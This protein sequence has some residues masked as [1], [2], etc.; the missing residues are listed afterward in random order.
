MGD[1]ECLHVLAFASW[2]RRSLL[3]DILRGYFRATVAQK[4]GVPYARGLHEGSKQ[5]LQLYQFHDDLE[6]RAWLI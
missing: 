3:R 1:L 6:V 2:A 5:E 4:L